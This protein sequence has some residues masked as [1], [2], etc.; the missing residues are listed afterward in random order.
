VSR[1]AR[2]AGGPGPM[3]PG[4]EPRE[5][6]TAGRP[7]PA[8][9]R[10]RRHLPVMAS[11]GNKQARPSTRRSRSA[12]GP[13]TGDA[14][15]RG[16]PSTSP[17]CRRT[18]TNSGMTS[19]GA[20][21]CPVDTRVCPVTKEANGEQSH[22]TAQPSSCSRPSRPAGDRGRRHPHRR[23]EGLQIGPH[24]LVGQPGASA[25]TGCRG[26]PLHGQGPW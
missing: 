1:D 11:S 4:T 7:M 2:T 6:R 19:P 13:A 21:S 5:L 17:I 14:L 12:P 18:G 10:A 16:S 9:R 23:G 24:V 3:T 26:R 22:V 25:F 15:R 20:T 8:V